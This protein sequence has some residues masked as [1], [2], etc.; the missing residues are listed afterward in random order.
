MGNLFGFM[1]GSIMTLLVGNGDDKIDTIKGLAF[2]LG[3]FLLGLILILFMKEEKNR[4]KHEYE[5]YTKRK[6]GKSENA[7]PEGK[8]YLPTDGNINKEST[9]EDI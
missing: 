1:M 2:S 3:M 4:E 8:D 9:A 6:S 5:A 7:Y